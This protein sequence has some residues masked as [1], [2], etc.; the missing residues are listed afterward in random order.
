MEET[1]RVSTVNDQMR[2]ALGMTGSILYRY[3]AALRYAQQD[4]ALERK[5]VDDACEVIDPSVERDFDSIPLGQAGATPVV[6]NQRVPRGHPKKEV[7]PHW[8]I[9]FVLQVREP[10]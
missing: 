2:H 1:A 5:A 8:A 7:P 10:V 9:E 4:E 6:T 3:C